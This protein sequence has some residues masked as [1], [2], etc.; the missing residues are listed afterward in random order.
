MRVLWFSVTP[1]M[2]DEK[3][4]GGWI[5]SLEQVIKKYSTDIELAIAF[6][7]NLHEFK[8][9]K[10]GTTYYPICVSN[11]IGDRLTEKIYADYKWSRIKPKMM[12]IIQDFEPDI[13][14][15]FGTEWSY[16]LIT[17]DTDIPVAIHMQGFSN[18]YNE[19][20]EL[21]YSDWEYI[22][23]NNFNPKVAFTVLTNRGKNRK[24]LMRENHIMK[25]NEFYMGRTMWDK[26]IVKNYSPNSKYYYCAEALRPEIYRA[27]KWKSDTKIEN[28]IVTITQAGILKGNEIIL[29]TAKIL[30]DT[31]EFRF[32][33]RVAGNPESFKLAERK[34]GISHDKYNIK[35]LGMIPAEEVARE[36]AH[37]TM[38]VHPAIIDNSPNSLC[39]AQ[40]IGCPVV[41]ANVGGIASLVKD[42]ETG[43]LYPYNEPHTLAFCIMELCHDREKLKYLSNNERAVA[44]ERHNPEMIYQSLHRI[45]QD[46]INT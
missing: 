33:W 43:V 10:N 5:A 44:L 28:T 6:E 40:V 41:A 45:Y 30:K 3:K 27:E 37:A 4:Y 14:Q 19:S 23:C 39:E 7:Y 25:I 36:L 11:T 20:C 35:L 1:S 29:R 15:C 16:G 24:Y 26:T 31:F 38:Y 32:E 46:I 34:T 17:E 22:K 21:A 2:F 18:I 12:E 8:V 9:V 13:I 42:R